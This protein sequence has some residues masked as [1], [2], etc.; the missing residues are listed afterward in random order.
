MKSRKN[1]KTWLN[2]LHRGSSRLAQGPS[3]I[4]CDE[5]VRATD[6]SSRSVEF[7]DNV[8][9]RRLSSSPSPRNTMDCVHL[10]Q[11]DEATAEGQ[12]GRTGIASSCRAAWHSCGHMIA[13]TFDR[14]DGDRANWRSRLP[15]SKHFAGEGWKRP[16][17][18]AWRLRMMKPLLL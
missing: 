10:E 5:R 2:T 15:I 16:L 1:K 11:V 9:G 6:L 14:N 12:P 17:Q 18:A 3:M 4:A 13:C 8:D 7:I